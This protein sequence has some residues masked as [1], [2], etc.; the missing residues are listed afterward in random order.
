MPV[1]SLVLLGAGLLSCEDNESVPAAWDPAIQT[2]TVPAILADNAPEPYLIQVE[3]N[4]PADPTEATGL[5]VRLEF[6]GP[7]LSAPAVWTLKD[8]GGQPLATGEAGMLQDATTS[9]DN[10]PGDLVFT[11]QGWWTWPRPWVWISAPAPAVT[12]WWPCSAATARSS[13]AAAG[14]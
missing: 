8:D 4:R 3:I 14:R 11:G 2:V 13:T 6:S 5:Q 9:G 12:S 7:G 10:I 1:W